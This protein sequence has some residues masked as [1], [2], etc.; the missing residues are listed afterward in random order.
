M[1]CWLL[2][3]LPAAARKP[4]VPLAR[5]DT[6]APSQP[7]EAPEDRLARAR[8][9]FL[10]NDFPATVQTLRGLVYPEVLLHSEEDVRAVHRMLAL[11]PDFALDPVLD[12]PQAIAFL[13]RL[14]AR[15]RQRLDEIERRRREE[16]AAA[17][18]EESGGRARPRT[19]GCARRR[20][21]PGARSSHCWWSATTA[22]SV[23]Y[24]LA[25]GSSRTGRK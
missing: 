3:A 24:R 18:R 8:Q 4:P 25:R 10:N 22:G 20:S 16:A 7:Q 6:P 15:Q 21:E 5:T 17:A 9:S 1:L 13:E 12:P 19:G 14:R 2:L 11:R 23:W